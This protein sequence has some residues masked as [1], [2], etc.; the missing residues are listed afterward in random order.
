MTITMNAV[1]I[2]TPKGRDEIDSKT[3]VSKQLDQISA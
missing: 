2:K 3:N 1:F